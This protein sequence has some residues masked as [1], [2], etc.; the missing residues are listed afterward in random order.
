MNF[1]AGLF[2]GIAFI[3]AIIG[4]IMVVASLAIPAVQ[5][6]PLAAAGVGIAAIPYFIASL[7]RKAQVAQLLTKI[8]RKP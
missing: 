6:G 5:A 2:D 7:Q 3:G 1:L 4:G 8:E